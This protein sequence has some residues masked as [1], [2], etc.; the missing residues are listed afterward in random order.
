MSFSCDYCGTNS[1]ETKTSG[2][3]SEYGTKIVLK[4]PNAQDLK[5]DLFKVLMLSYLE[6]IVRC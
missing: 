3:I 4:N 1:T 6:L 2:G 5:R